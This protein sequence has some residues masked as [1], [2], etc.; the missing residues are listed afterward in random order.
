MYGKIMM[1]REKR[2]RYERRLQKQLALYKVEW[3]APGCRYCRLS[4][5]LSQKT[6]TALNLSDADA[7]LLYLFFVDVDDD[8]SGEV[9]VCAA[10]CVCVCVCVCVYV[11]VRVR[12][13]VMCM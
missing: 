10:L 3:T 1:N 8:G 13:H 12:V 6:I 11:R 9:R 5:L 7:K 4:F 2:K